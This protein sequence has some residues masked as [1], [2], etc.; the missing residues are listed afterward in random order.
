MKG[1]QGYPS[2]QRK[3]EGMDFSEQFSLWSTEH[4]V[5]LQVTTPLK[6]RPVVSLKILLHWPLAKLTEVTRNVSPGFQQALERS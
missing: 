5:L 2:S 6:T 4:L 1:S 3:L